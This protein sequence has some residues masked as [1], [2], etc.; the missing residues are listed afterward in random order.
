MTEIQLL[1]DDSIDLGM[2]VVHRVHGPLATLPARWRT[3]D[4]QKASCSSGPYL[5]VRTTVPPCFATIASTA[6]IIPTLSRMIRAETAKIA[7]LK[8]VLDC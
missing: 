4:R 5:S 1:Q 2:K 7:G 6:N 8:E 3:C